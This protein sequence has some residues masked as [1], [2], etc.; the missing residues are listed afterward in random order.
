[1]GPSILAGNLGAKRGKSPMAHIRAEQRAAD[2]ATKDR[3]RGNSPGAQRRGNSPGRG[4]TPTTAGAGHLP[5]LPA[6]PTRS[7]RVSPRGAHGAGAGGQPLLSSSS[8]EEEEH[9]AHTRKF[10]QHELQSRATPGPPSVQ[11]KNTSG[12]A[13]SPAPPSSAGAGA[14]SPKPAGTGRPESHSAT[15]GAGGRTT[16]GGGA[17]KVYGAIAMSRS[18]FDLWLTKKVSDTTKRKRI[19]DWISQI[20][21][22]NTNNNCNSSPSGSPNRG[23][24]GVF[25]PGGSTRSPVVPST[26]LSV[27]RRC[28][29]FDKCVEELNEFYNQQVHMTLMAIVFG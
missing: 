6:P 2:Q 25:S 1:M 20:P 26:Q 5:S 4:S 22:T 28:E 8:D 29:I 27:H 15:T 11:P 9:K 18:E 10:I 16:A 7:P 23:R 21:T 13:A 19:R 17:S 3:I 12:G 14:R 24:S